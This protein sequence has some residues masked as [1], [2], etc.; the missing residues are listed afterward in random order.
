MD[1]LVDPEF[2]KDLDWMS[3]FVRDEVEPLDLLFLNAGDMYD[4]KNKRARALIA[5]LLEQ[6]KARGLWA[7]HLQARDRLRP[8]GRGA[9]GSHAPTASD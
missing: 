7:C 8:P 3:L 6:V 5:P 9:R 4:T 2:Q 1:F